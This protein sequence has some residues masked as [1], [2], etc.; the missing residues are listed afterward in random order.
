MG[1]LS[2]PGQGLAWTGLAAGPLAW[3]AHHQLGSDLN[4]ADCG[5]GSAMT[6]TLIGAA[7]LLVIAVGAFAAAR[8]FRLAGPAHPTTRFIATM[9]LLGCALFGLTVAIQIMAGLVVPACFQ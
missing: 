9:A 3:A 8:G 5:R 1:K 7:A 2:S 4:F 6:V